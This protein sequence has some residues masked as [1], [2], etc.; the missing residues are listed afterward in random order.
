[1]GS[2]DP[3]TNPGRFFIVNKLVCL[4]LFSM[5]VT[6][7]GNGSL[8]AQKVEPPKIV[9][10]K[11][12]APKPPELLKV[13]E[14]TKALEAAKAPEPAKAQETPKAAPKVEGAAKAQDTSE[15]QEA[16]KTQDVPKAAEAPKD[17]PAKGP[18]IDELTKT[19]DE[20]NK[21][22]ESANAAIADVKLTWKIGADTVWVLITGMLVFF[23]NLGFACVE[24]G[25]CRAKNCVNI[26]SKNFIVFAVTT[27]GF[28][29]VGWGIMFG[30][31]DDWMGKSGITMVKGVDSS[32]QTSIPGFKGQLIA[33][34]KDEKGLGIDVDDKD[35]AKKFPEVVKAVESAV[36]KFDKTTSNKTAK[37]DD[38]GNVVKDKDGKPE[39]VDA[40]I[41][42]KITAGGKTF[43]KTYPVK[44]FY[45]GDYSA[46]AWTGIPLWAKFFFQLVFAG[47]AA[48]IVSG[49]VA[50]RI[51]Y[52]SFIIFSFAMA[53]FIYPVVGHWVWGGGYLQSRGFLDFAGSTQVHSIGG[54]AALIAVIILGPRIGKYGPGGKVNA[55][56]GHNMTAATIGCLILWFGWFGFNPGSTMGVDPNAIA[57]VAITTNLAAAMATLTATITAWCVM[58][59]PDIGMTLNGCLAGL[60]AIT[61]PCAFVSAEV[62]VLIGGIAG[63]IVVLAVIGFDKIGID[64][65][66]GA[67]SVH[68]VNGVFGTICVGLFATAD[69]LPRAG[70]P[71]AKPGLFTGGD[72]S[73]LIMQLTGVAFTAV[74]VLL[75]SG[76]AWLVIKAVVGMRVSPQ[77]E[78]EGLDIGEHG[79]EAYHG[80][81]MISP[82]ILASG[83]EPKPATM[84]KDA[85]KRFSV[86]VEGMAPDKIA[87][88]WG[89]MCTPTKNPSPD[90]LAV[91]PRMTLLQGNK[92]KFIEGNPEQISAHL[93]K[94]LQS[95]S[96]G[97]T[98]RAYVEK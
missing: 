61:A 46:I 4:M 11:V 8:V 51:K 14:E 88:I 55:I 56:P 36:E 49:A 89:E 28:W 84:P 15:T 43:E 24:S 65:P 77:E 78:M 80:F 29:L 96:N 42:V 54:W 23:M 44:D 70:N 90:F 9:P 97:G 92:F 5:A 21:K 73:Q 98:V 26:L 12:E 85:K 59:K 66:V 25:M 58:G 86:I 45:W 1:M 83:S 72:A 93:A 50:E 39:E 71:A 18:T 79:N 10:P 31:G 74:Y 38:K 82:E 53:I 16:P 13:Q 22:L 81:A 64:D 91:Y 6:L 34:L 94:L 20:T 33:D 48:T 19:I 17:A 41:P 87:S 40:E 32:P 62:S 75:A 47:T 57:E 2:L 76:V 60:V 52:H 69:R 30:N 35:Q 67:T 7:S 63:V 68:L 37:L 95:A 3:H 27:I